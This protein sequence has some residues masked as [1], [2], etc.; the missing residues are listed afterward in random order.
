MDHL[1]CF[2][3]RQHIIR[4]S[5]AIE[6]MVKISDHPTRR[7]NKIVF[8]RNSELW[9]KLNRINTVNTLLKSPW[10]HIFPWN[11]TKMEFHSD[12]MIAGPQNLARAI[13]GIHLENRKQSVWLVVLCRGMLPCCSGIFSVT[14]IFHSCKNRVVLVGHISALANCCS[15]WR[16]LGKNIPLETLGMVYIKGFQI[17]ASSLFNV[18]L[19]STFGTFTLM[20]LRRE[21]FLTGWFSILPRI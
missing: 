19:F 13:R 7:R 1:S 10:N 4:F 17:T 2:D 5:H 11:R 9:C 12:A 15:C 20:I 8:L 3:W 21:E 14:G 6:C 18:I 16:K